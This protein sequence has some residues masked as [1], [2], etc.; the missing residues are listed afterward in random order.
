MRNDKLKNYLHLH[1]II[2]IWG[3]TAV[4]GA[5]I[6]IEAIPLVWYRMLIA[7]VFVLG[8]IF[9]QK[10]SLKVP[11][12]TLF[13][14]ILTGGLIAL[15][16]LTFFGAIKVSNVSITLAM[17]ST[18]AFFTA[19]LEPIWYKRRIIWYEIVFGLI[20]ILGL[21][22]I[23]KVEAG[24]IEGILL[25]LFSALMASLFSLLNGKLVQEYKP[26]VISFYELL[27]GAV[28]ISIYL[29]AQG[30]FDAEFFSLSN[31][32]WFYILVLAVICTAYAFIASVKVMRFISP[33]TVM[34]SINLEPVYGIILA[35]LILGDAEKM[36]FEFY[37]GAV[38]I[39]FTVIANGILKH[40][41]KES[42]YRISENI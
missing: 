21:Y 2:F 37:I 14:F 8:F 19:I 15:H 16:W 25:A 29:F 7:S 34:L 24:Y 22:I 28:F 30:G 33:Y 27:A 3:F 18:G 17:M 11:R 6:S 26:S 38:I 9:L 41:K 13:T 42:N 36:S 31:S 35:F 1:F 12:K 10:I 4:L 5:L 32:D 40:R 23:F 39:L 20:I